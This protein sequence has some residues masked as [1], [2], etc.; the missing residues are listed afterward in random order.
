MNAALLRRWGMAATAM[1][2]VQCAQLGGM[3]HTLL[4]AESQV[5]AL[6]NSIA[7]T[8]A[9]LWLALAISVMASFVQ[10]SLK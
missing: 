7:A 4:G 8:P 2:A 1:V 3:I 10:G 5:P 9:Q 6:F